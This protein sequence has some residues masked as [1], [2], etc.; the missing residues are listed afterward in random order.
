M[1]VGVL[2]LLYGCMMNASAPPEQDGT[3]LLSFAKGGLFA[4]ET[5]E[6]ELDMD[7]ATYDVQGSGP[8]GAAF[9]QQGVTGTTVVQESL[10][11][12]RWTIVVYGLNAGG[13]IIGSGSVTVEVVSGQVASAEVTVV[14]LAGE[15]TLDVGVTWPQGVLAD[16]SVSGILTPAGGLSEDV[17]F[18]LA[19]DFLSANYLTSLPN[20]YYTLST[21]LMDGSSMVWGTV[22][23]VRIVAGELSSKVYALVRDVNRGGL[24]LEITPDMQNPIEIGFNVAE[25]VQLPPGGEVT[26]VATTS[27]AVDGYQ[28]YLQGVP[29]AGET[30]DTVTIGSGLE[31]GTYWLD[32]VVVK[33]G[34]LSSEGIVIEVTE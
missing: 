17:S 29:L 13:V 14:P 24:Q 2:S 32:L 8:G 11:P 1:L 23:A 28:W 20:G 21:R 33:G 27:E 5:I 7:I 19:G 6:P 9:R 18:I 34:V 4:L 10:V 31:A 26:V 12:G 30:T 16:P 22:E 15:G 3:L 25:S